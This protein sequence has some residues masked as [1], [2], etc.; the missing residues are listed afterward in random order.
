MSYFH[1]AKAVK[2]IEARL[3]LRLPRQECN[4][5]Q[6]ENHFQFALISQI[7]PPQK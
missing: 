5:C 3:Q 1:N 4:L 2:T 7:Q 6:Q